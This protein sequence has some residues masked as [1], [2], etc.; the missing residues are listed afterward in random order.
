MKT[1]SKKIFFISILSLIIV[2]SIIGFAGYKLF[3][4]PAFFP[5]TKTYIYVDRDD[6]ADSL[7]H[8][9]EATS[10]P[11][12]M[13]GFKKMA[14]FRDLNNN[15]RTGKYAINADDNVYALYHRLSRGHKEPVNLVVASTR[16]VEFLSRNLAKQL[17]IDSLEIS[18]LFNDPNELKQLNYTTETLNG[19]IIPDT[20]QVYWDIS[21]QDLVERLVKEYKRFWNEKRLAQAKEMGFTPNEISTIASIVDEETNNNAEKPLVAGLYVNRLRKNIPLQADPTVKFALQDFN[22]RRI[23]KEH[24]KTVSPYNTYIN[25]GLPP[26]PIRIPTK[27]GLESVLNHTKHDYIYMCAKEDLSGTHNF[28]ANYN[29]HLRNARKYWDALNKRKIF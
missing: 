5:T 27:Q 12:S 9:I 7:I 23:T 6:N 10:N 13:W 18:Q 28:A 26:G 2:A 16:N 29:D 24:L 4:A 14:K 11:T 15:I 3:F 21:A 8:K 25:T 1:K 17:M 20:Y 19:M 22:L